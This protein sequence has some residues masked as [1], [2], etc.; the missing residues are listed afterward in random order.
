MRSERRPI[1]RLY[2]I[3]AGPGDPEL[4][5]LRAWRIL[6]QVSVICVPKRGEKDASYAFSIVSQVV[7]PGRQEVVELLF[8]MSRDPARLLEARESALARVLARLDQGRDVAF[9]TEGDPFLYSTFI[10]IFSALR[11]RRPDIPIEVIP[12]VSS[13]TAAAAAAGLP[14]ADGDDLVAVVP[15]TSDIGRLRESLKHFQTVVFI[16]AS[17]N[18]DRVIDLLEE[19]GFAEAVGVTR[20]TRPDQEIVG[21]VRGLRGKKLDYFSIILA[22]KQ[23]KQEAS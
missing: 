8:P 22:K 3:G 1:G 2:G 23:A 14:L 18:T 13:V 9:V 4:L 6:Q 10:S 21:D 11:E 19:L 20:C 17:R 7:D 12:G 5:T 16:K 15:A